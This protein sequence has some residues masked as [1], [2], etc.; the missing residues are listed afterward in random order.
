MRIF[1]PMK[2][3]LIKR[4]FDFIHVKKLNEAGS[5]AAQAQ[6]LCIVM[7]EGIA[8]IYL[9]SKHTS[10]LK[11]KIEKHI[12]KKKGFAKKTETQKNKFFENIENALEM[13]FNP[14]NTSVNVTKSIKA[15]V[16]G[17]PGFYKD[18]LYAYLQEAAERKKSGF[19][20]DL[21]SKTILEHCSSGYKQSLHELMQSPAVSKKIENLTCF[22][23]GKHLDEFF[24]TLR[25]TDDKAC[26]GIKSVEFALGNLAVETL[27]V[28][29]HLFRAKNV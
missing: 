17:S 21:V 16:I 1:G 4:Q 5:D 22:S 2:I 27:L 3:T 9:V 18:Q 12:S 28:S 8:H 23:E 13:K 24:E 29:D 6:V 19:L 7:E 26:Y 20:Q 25:T 14:A 11:A 15:V 10:K